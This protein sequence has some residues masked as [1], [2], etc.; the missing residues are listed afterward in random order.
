MLTKNVYNIDLERYYE[1][2]IQM[3]RDLNSYKISE[4]ENILVY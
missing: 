3:L 4:K 1:K 2:T